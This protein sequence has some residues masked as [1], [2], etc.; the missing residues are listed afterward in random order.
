MIPGEQDLKNLRVTIKPLDGPYKDGVFNFI[1]SFSH[2]YPF[3]PPKVS[4]VEKVYHP[5]LNIQGGVCLNVLREEYKP[6]LTMTTFVIGEYLFHSWF[7][8]CCMFIEMRRLI[9]IFF[10]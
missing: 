9:V 3:T 5:N 6:T 8:N 2:N 10:L 4:I 7:L 1:F